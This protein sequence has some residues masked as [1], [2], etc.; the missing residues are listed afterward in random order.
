MCTGFEAAAIGALTSGGGEILGQNENEKAQGRYVRSQ[1]ETLGQILAKNDPLAQDSRDRFTGLVD[2][3]SAP[4]FQA[5]QQD[6]TGQRTGV[7]RG[8]M[9]PQGP[10]DA[11]ISGSAPGAV[12][13]LFD[14]KSADASTR[15][16]ER[17]DSVGKLGGFGDVFAR[18]GLANNE[19][20]RNVNVNNDLARGNLA[21]LPHMQQYA[22][23]ASQ[24][25]RSPLPGVLKGVGSVLGS[26]GGATPGAG[27]GP[28]VNWVTTV[29]GPR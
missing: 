14:S 2:T 6:L 25:A 16:G 8:N 24:K 13:A 20:G 7:L 19:V 4:N 21:I 9:A 28:N 5:K 11:N 15:S 17:A 29:Q 3:Y 23:I 10:V 1:N 26:M 18:Q 27:S 12:Q 22:G